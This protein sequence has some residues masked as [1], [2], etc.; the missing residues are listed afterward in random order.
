MYFGN[1]RILIFFLQS[2][3]LGIHHKIKVLT[4]RSAYSI[5]LEEVDIS[6]KFK[7]FGALKMYQ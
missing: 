5:Q 2:H 1:Y 4:G 3:I 6:G 7:F